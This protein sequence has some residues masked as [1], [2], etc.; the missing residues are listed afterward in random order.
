MSGKEVTS[1]LFPQE[2]R[3]T[4]AVQAETGRKPV[5]RASGPRDEGVPPSP[6]APGRRTEAGAASRRGQDAR[7]TQGR[8]A[9]ATNHIIRVAIE[10]AADSEFD[11]L[12][13]EELWPIVVGQRVE[14]P[15]GK[16][17]KIEAA[18]CVVADVPREK[19]FAGGKDGG[20][21]KSIV[22]RIEEEPLLGPQLMELAFWISDYYVC[23][24]GQVLAAMVPGAVKRGAGVKKRRCI[25]LADG[26][27]EKLAGLKGAK[28]KRIVEVL[29]ER[30]AVTAEAAV[31]AQ[32]LLAAADCGA[33]VL[34]KLADE[35]VVRVVQRKVFADLP[36]VPEGMMPAE[37]REVV[38]N[39]DQKVALEHISGQVRSGRFGV[40][41]LHG[42]TDSG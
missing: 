30:Q 9:F 42:V 33:P 11:Y 37:G 24:L 39:D 19:S 7:D 1:S 4:L 38:L 21:L 12:V 40:T 6:Q 8:D 25:Y 32:E 23:P 17:N 18:F 14:V 41:L 2:E 20:K 15:F 36:V 10:S 13:P 26:W 16:K 3:E 35:Q 34:K 27:E 29:R 22:R 31:D 5:S 28:Q